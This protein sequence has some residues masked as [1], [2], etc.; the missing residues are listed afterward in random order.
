[1]TIKTAPGAG[2]R[3]DEIADDIYRISTPVPPEMIPGGFTFNQFLIKDDAPLLYHTGLLKMFPVVREAVARV[4]PPESLRYVAFSH[5][6]ADEC[7][8]LNEFLN[9]APEAEPL[10]GM[11]AKMESA[12]EAL[13]HMVPRVH[14]IQWQGAQTVASLLTGQL[15]SGTVIYM[16]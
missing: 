13:N 16:K 1:M 6:E 4:L 3:I 12:F 11:V 5:Y 9:V 7:G 2:T 10:C 15:N 8:A 14:I